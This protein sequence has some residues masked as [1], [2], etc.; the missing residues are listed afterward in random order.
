MLTN[1]DS[2]DQFPPD[3]LKRGAAMLRAFPR[4]GG[5]L[6]RL[7]ARSSFLQRRGLATVTA[8]GLDPQRVESVAG[9][10]RDLAGRGRVEHGTVRDAGFGFGRSCPG[11]PQESGR[12]F[13]DLRRLRGAAARGKMVA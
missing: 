10:V 12:L 11:A 7:Q 3:K 4:L 8:H 13:D 6:L 2:Y 1:C 5:A 9:P